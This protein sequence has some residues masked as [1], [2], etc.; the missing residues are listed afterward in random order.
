[1]SKEKTLDRFME[2]QD[3]EAEAS[4]AKDLISPVF[5]PMLEEML[6]PES[7]VEVIISDLVTVMMPKADAAKR[8]AYD[9]IFS[10]KELKTL[11]NF[12]KRHPEIAKKTSAAFRRTTEINQLQ[13]QDILEVIV[14]HM[15]EMRDEFTAMMAKQAGL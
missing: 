8:Q 11:I 6:I 1:M 14:K 15:P 5:K 9:E 13:P 2:I 4:F 10:E 7:K 12:S 3:K